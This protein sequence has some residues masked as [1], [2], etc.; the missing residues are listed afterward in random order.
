VVAVNQAKN[1]AIT[2]ATK[3]FGDVQMLLSTITEDRIKVFKLPFIFENFAFFQIRKRSPL[4]FFYL[5][6]SGG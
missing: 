5:R 3:T 1:V 2:C 6:D 4:M